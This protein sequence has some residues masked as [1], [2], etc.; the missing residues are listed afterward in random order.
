MSSETKSLL[1]LTLLC[2]FSAAFYGFGAGVL[3]YQAAYEGTGR[4]GLIQFTRLVV[5]LALAVLL[6]YK[7]R[8]KGVAAALLMVVGATAAEWLLLPVSYSWA[9]IGDPAGYAEKLG[10][11]ERPTY[12]QWATFD[13][14]GVGI[15]AA[16]AQGLR[17]IAMA[18]PQH[19]DDW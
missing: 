14:V 11:A 7:G 2:T 8:W 6:V 9:S 4:E 15:T 12:I 10:G 5:Y 1:G 3:S 19:R 16:F 17:I 13:V 18:N